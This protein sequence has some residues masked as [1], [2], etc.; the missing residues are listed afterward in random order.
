MR[1]AVDLRSL[2]SGFVS[3]VE[4]YTLN[5]LEH[6]LSLDKQN[7][8]LLFY[9]AWHKPAVETLHYLNSQIVSTRIPNK[10]LN[11]SLKAKVVSLDKF[12]GPVDC[13]FMPNLNQ[14]NVGPHLKLVVTV[15]DLSPVVSPE[16]YDLK[17]RLW[18]KFL[19]FNEIFKRADKIFAVSHYTKLDLIRLFGVAETKIKVIHPGI[20]HK[21]FSDDIEPAKLR[22]ARNLYGLPGEYILFLNTIEPRKNLNNLIKAFEILNS[23]AD[24]VVAGKPGW[25]HRKI[26][27]MIKKSKKASKIKYLGY[28]DEVYKAAV[29][30]LAKV[31]VYPSFYEGFGFQPLEAMACGVPVIASQLTALPEIV[32][33]GA[34]LVNPYDELS[35]K[36]ALEALLTNTALRQSLIAKGKNRAA[37]F[38]WN[39]T[40]KKVLWELTNL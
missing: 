36:M 20:D 11:L 18:H 38:N 2:Q 17:R 1:I 37:D 4:N 9:N 23:N 29:I 13:F 7:S 14:F 22:M 25:K 35:I 32:R 6:L 33:D 19:G 15:H 10:L 12:L 30:R 3:G 26:F 5:L 8:Y 21:N 40:A 39:E 28:I 24:L 27:R 31:L 34:L 16:F